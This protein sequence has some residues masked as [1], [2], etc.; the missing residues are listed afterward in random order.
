MRR[1]G[2]NEVVV[3]TSSIL[4]HASPRHFLSKQILYNRDSA[5]ERHLVTT[6]LLQVPQG[7]NG[8]DPPD[9]ESPRGKD[10]GLISSM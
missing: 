8:S 10:T 9:Q 4:H 5:Q 6:V 1:R 3:S 2:C 7:C